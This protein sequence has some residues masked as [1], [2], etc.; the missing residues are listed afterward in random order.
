MVNLLYFL[1]GKTLQSRAFRLIADVR[2]CIPARP[3]A[4]KWT[5]CEAEVRAVGE[6]RGREVREGLQRRRLA[7]HSAVCG[8]SD[9]DGKTRSPHQSQSRF[10]GRTVVTF[11]SSGLVSPANWRRLQPVLPARL[12]TQV[13][14]G[15]KDETRHS[16]LE[17][18]NGGLLIEP[19]ETAAGSKRSEERHKGNQHENKCQ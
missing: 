6:G 16:C 3:Q 15:H 1:G 10:F 8:T 9:T 4:L 18:S 14:H 2:A 7:T 13:L 19:H 17:S 5:G 12:N 11:L